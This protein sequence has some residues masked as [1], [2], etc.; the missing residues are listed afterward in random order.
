MTTPHESDIGVCGGHYWIHGDESLGCVPPMAG[1]IVP[2]ELGLT[3]GNSFT[4][5]A[6]PLA[7]G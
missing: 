4:L 5:W 1:D 6:P 3:D 2:I 7:G